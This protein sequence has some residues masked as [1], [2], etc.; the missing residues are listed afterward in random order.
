MTSLYQILRDVLTWSWDHKRAAGEILLGVML[1]FLGWRYNVDQAALKKKADD[2]SG[3][4]AGIGLEL[5]ITQNQLEIA[6]READG[7]ISH[8]D[9]YVPPEGYVLVDQKEK[10]ALQKQVDDLTAKLNAAI[11][12]GDSKEAD[13]IKTEIG[14][15]DPGIAIK[16]KDHGF[17]FNPGF[18]LD[19][20]DRGVKIRVDFKWAYYNRYGLIFGGGPNGI[21]PGLTRHIDDI[22]WGH[23]KNVEV[24]G[25]WNALK[26]YT[27]TAN[28]TFGLRS[29]F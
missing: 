25:Q 18:G 14:K 2:A 16:V 22:I 4:A 9:I 27:G 8:K 11:K 15:I 12:N 19:W 3:L 6:K 26:P 5:K 10:D 23:P 28:Y 29:N 13:N 7:S 20:A 1:L 24:F 17:T 21:G